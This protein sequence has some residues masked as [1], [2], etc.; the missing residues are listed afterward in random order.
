MGTQMSVLHLNRV[1]FIEMSKQNFTLL[2][3]KRIIG[4]L[5]VDFA[6]LD[7]GRILSFVGCTFLVKRICL[8]V[9]CQYSRVPYECVTIS[10]WRMLV[11][12]GLWANPV[13]G[14]WS[15][16]FNINWTLCLKILT[17]SDWVIQFWQARWSNQPPVKSH[18]SNTPNFRLHSHRF[19]GLAHQIC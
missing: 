8:E 4:P 10:A 19:W 6:S 18:R 1:T 2:P 3:P 15:S 9:A 12:F 5:R 17:F 16:L 7:H 13:T 14:E 11:L